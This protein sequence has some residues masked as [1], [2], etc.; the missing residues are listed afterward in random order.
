MPMLEMEDR[1]RSLDLESLN[2]P[3]VATKR[4]HL[5]R[6]ASSFISNGSPGIKQ[7]PSEILAEDDESTPAYKG[8]EVSG[9][10]SHILDVFLY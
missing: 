1:K 2:N 8:L 5:D 7:D 4:P 9:N 10:G 3:A 6:S